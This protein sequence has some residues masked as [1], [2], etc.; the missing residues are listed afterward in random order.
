MGLIVCQRGRS[1]PNW[2]WVRFPT[3]LPPRRHGRRCCRGQTGGSGA[4]GD[5]ASVHDPS[6]DRRHRTGN[7]NGFGILSFVRVQTC[8]VH[9]IMPSLFAFDLL[10]RR[11]WN[12]Y[13]P[14]RVSCV[15]WRTVD[16]STRRDPNWVACCLAD[17]GR[18][19]VC[20][21]P[22]LQRGRGDLGAPAVS[23]S[24]FLFLTGACERTYS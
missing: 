14:L 4:S 8:F 24:C 5:L 3:P 18:R 22:K 10:P 12:P 21:L 15:Q 19:N 23:G 17:R 13:L 1:G 2:E 11:K 7:T 16:K 9:R 6:M 20:S